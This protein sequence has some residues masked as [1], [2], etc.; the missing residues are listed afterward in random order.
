MEDRLA[1]AM[2]GDLRKRRRGD[3]RGVARVGAEAQEG[4]A[5]GLMW[6]RSVAREH[7]GNRWMQRTRGMSQIHIGSKDKGYE[8]DG[9]WVVTE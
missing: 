2:V 1:S 4:D 3:R 7:K 9:Y 6:G 5:Q 8:S